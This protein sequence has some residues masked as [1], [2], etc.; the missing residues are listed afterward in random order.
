[1]SERRD[2]QVLLSQLQNHLSDNVPRHLYSSLNE[3]EYERFSGNSSVNRIVNLF[4][5]LFDQGKLNHSDLNDLIEAFREMGLDDA[6]RR[7]LGK[8]KHLSS[9]I[10]GVESS[11]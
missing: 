11:L 5:L 10:V 2:F 4:Q 3:I 1:M 7:L 9:T 6:A 8:C